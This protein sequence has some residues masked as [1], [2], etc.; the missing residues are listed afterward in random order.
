MEIQISRSYSRLTRVINKLQAQYLPMFCG[1]CFCLGFFSPGSVISPRKV[2]WNWTKPRQIL[3]RS[4]NIRNACASLEIERFDKGLWD[5]IDLGIILLF[6]F[7]PKNKNVI[8]FVCEVPVAIIVPWST[9]EFFVYWKA[10]YDLSTS[11]TM[12]VGFKLIFQEANMSILPSWEMT[13]QSYQILSW[14]QFLKY[15]FKRVK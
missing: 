8:S 15:S 12:Q 14:L 6:S 7:L 10:D 2:S 13:K 1:F 3:G 9:K 11:N 4:K 5:C